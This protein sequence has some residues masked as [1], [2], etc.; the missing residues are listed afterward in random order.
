MGGEEHSVNW[1]HVAREY[2]EKWHHQQQIREAVGAESLLTPE[3]FYPCIDTFMQALPHAYRNVNASD[4]DTI[5]ITVTTEAGGNWYLTKTFHEW[6]LSKSAGQNH[7]VANVAVEPGVIWKIFTKA[8]DP[9]DA[10]RLLN[11]SGN[12]YLGSHLA[13]VL[14]IMA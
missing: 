10:L 13:N 7:L 9:K 3:L 11:V 8:I 4:G 14:A 12:R 5:K 2:T 6:I 1:F